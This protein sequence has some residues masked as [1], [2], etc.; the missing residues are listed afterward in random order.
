MQ[1]RVVAALARQAPARGPALLVLRVFRPSTRSEGVAPSVT[2]RDP[3]QAAVR[4]YPSDDRCHGRYL[5]ATNRKA[6]TIS[7]E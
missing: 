5:D 7:A 1:R 6:L 2:P 4:G 3:T